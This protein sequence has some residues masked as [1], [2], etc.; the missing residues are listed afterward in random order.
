M[1]TKSDQHSRS[2]SDDSRRR[3]ARI[4]AIVL[5]FIGILTVALVLAFMLFTMLASVHTSVSPQR[6]TLVGFILL[7]AL[8]LLIYLVRRGYSNRNK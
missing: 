8:P 1:P 3:D 4:P 5:I 2:A 7:G 6:A